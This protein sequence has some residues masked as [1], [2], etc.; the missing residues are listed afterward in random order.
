MLCSHARTTKKTNRSSKVY[1]IST[2][3]QKENSFERNDCPALLTA[4]LRKEKEVSFEAGGTGLL[5]VIM[6]RRFLKES[7]NT[8]VNENPAGTGQQGRAQLTGLNGVCE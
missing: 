2:T 5:I 6:T 8:A 1:Q 3:T 7:G 4:N